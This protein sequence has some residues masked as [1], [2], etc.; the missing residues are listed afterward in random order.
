[1]ARC[2]CGYTHAHLQHTCWAPPLVPGT[3]IEPGPR[4]K[5]GFLHPHIQ[6][7]CSSF[8]EIAKKPAFVDEP[9]TEALAMAQFVQ[10]WRPSG[11]CPTCPELGRPC[12]S[13]YIRA[14]YTAEGYDRRFG[15]KKEVPA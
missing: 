9:E 11:M 13:C 8:P 2:I 10:G 14:G 6:H 7:D 12:R 1:M 15:D 5:C 3:R 4:C